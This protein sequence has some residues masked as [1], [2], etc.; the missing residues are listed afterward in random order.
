MN[1]YRADLHIHTC[2]SPCGSLEMSPSV[3]VKTALS[4]GMDAIAI[5]DHNSTLQ[6]QEI[7]VLGR[8]VGLVVFGGAEVTTRE[9]AHCVALFGTDEALDTFQLYLEKHLP[10][11]ANN[12]DYFGDQVWVNRENEILGEIPSLLISALDQSVDQVA[13]TV[14]DL[15]GLFVAAH[16][17]RPSFSLIGQLGFI[18]PTLPL[19]GIE[20]THIETYEKL[21]AMHPYLQN[22]IQYRASDA[23]YPD[24]IGSRYLVWQGENL[25][26]EELKMA[27]TK[28]GVYE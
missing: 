19:D 23:H 27:F 13:R 24:Q 1:N 8:E 6:C 3:I 10:P 26:F 15:G 9:E 14:K 12:P 5:T 28:K 2:L 21:V 4:K 18:D 11:I 20:Y 16:V 17:D 25:S 22:Y 7:Q